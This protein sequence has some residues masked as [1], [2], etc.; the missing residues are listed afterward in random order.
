[1]EPQKVEPENEWGPPK[2]ELEKKWELL[3]VEAPM[4][5]PENQTEPSM[6]ELEKAEPGNQQGRQTQT[7]PSMVELEWRLDTWGKVESGK[8][9]PSPKEWEGSRAERRPSQTP[10][11][12]AAPVMRR[13][14]R[15]DRLRSSAEA[16]RSQRDFRWV[17]TQDERRLNTQH[18]R[19]W[20]G[21]GAR[22]ASES[23]RKENRKC[24]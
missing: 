24:S 2:V 12:R 3:L 19:E 22:T 21:F 17:E 10:R 5:E 13:H 18:P 20:A 15:L 16:G 7:E 1:M 23:L 4:V 9:L 14:P 11:K 8:R 6:V